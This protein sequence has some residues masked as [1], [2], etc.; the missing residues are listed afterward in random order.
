MI[1]SLRLAA[2]AALLA[3][4]AS[5]ASAD[6]GAGVQ[7]LIDMQDPSLVSKTFCVYESKVYGENTEVCI[8]ASAKMVCAPVDPADATKGVK[9][10]VTDEKTRCRK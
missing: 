9:W 4:L 5:V 1:R 6:E 8:S 10:T 7:I 3:G 2:A